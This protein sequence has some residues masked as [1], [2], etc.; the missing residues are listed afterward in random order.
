MVFNHNGLALHFFM[1]KSL[2]DDRSSFYQ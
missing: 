1:T 2:L